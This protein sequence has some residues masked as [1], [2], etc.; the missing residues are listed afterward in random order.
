MAE[1]QHAMRCWKAGGAVS[2]SSIA[3][4]IHN[5]IAD[6]LARTLREVACEQVMQREPL[7]L[8]PG[9][10]RPDG[11]VAPSRTPGGGAAWFVDVTRVDSSVLNAEEAKI[12][13]YAEFGVGV[14]HTTRFLP[15]ALNNLGDLGPRSAKTLSALASAAAH[16][17]ERRDRGV[18]TAM[19]TAT[20]GRALWSGLA[21]RL[22]AFCDAVGVR[23]A[24]V[25]PAEKKW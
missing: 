3:I 13:K 15:L 20:V 16:T 11:Y 4:G 21:R 6:E 9:Q 12:K 5:A 17:G 19:V 10:A 25:A 22:A 7:N 24:A 2:G 18:V 8:L 14:D 1:T 23:P